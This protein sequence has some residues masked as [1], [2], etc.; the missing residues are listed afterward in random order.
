M[1]LLF[2]TTLFILISIG[3]FWILG[4]LYGLFRKPKMY[5]P[6]SLAAK[7]AITAV[8]GGLFFMVGGVILST[9]VFNGEMQKRNDYRRWPTILT[10]AAI[11]TSCSIFIIYLF[12]FLIW[13]ALQR[14]V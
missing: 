5:F 1:E 7:M 3:S 2:Y 8:L 9:V 12:R 6:I 14:G 10:G 11:S 4:S 13:D